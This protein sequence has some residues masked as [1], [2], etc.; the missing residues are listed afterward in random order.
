[1][2][3]NE[4]DIDIPDDLYQIVC[5]RAVDEGKTV[6]TVILEALARALGIDPSIIQTDSTPT[7]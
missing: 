3:N 4:Y 6:N 5:Q 7:T 1:M 2:S